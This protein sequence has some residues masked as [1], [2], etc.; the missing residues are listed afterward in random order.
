MD[1]EHLTQY[2]RSRSIIGAFYEVY[3]TLNF[4][5][6]ETFY[7]Q[8]L[9]YELRRLGHEVSREYAARV[10]CKEL[11]LGFLRLDMVV[12]QSIVVEVKATATLHPIAKRQLRNYLRATNLELGLL[13]HFGMKAV[14]H[15]VSS[16][17]QGSPKALPP[18]PTLP[19]PR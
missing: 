13:L 7:T 2:R 14:V 15:R 8:A 18:V 3:R 4:G 19:G 9:E 5:F 6:L 11:E 17:N 10:R 16:P 1:D 12:D